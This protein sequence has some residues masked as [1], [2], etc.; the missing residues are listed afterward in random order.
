MLLGVPGLSYADYGACVEPEAFSLPRA[1]KSD[2]EAEHWAKAVEQHSD[3]VA[4]YLQCLSDYGNRNS[5]SFSDEDEAELIAEIDDT[6]LYARNV[7][8]NWNK[9]FGKYQ[10]RR[11][12]QQN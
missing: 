9:L 1:L 5:K 11:L 4:N 2:A 10:K 7:A 12:K 6:V 8:D 3:S